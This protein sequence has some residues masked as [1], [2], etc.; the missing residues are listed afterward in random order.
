MEL[1]QIHPKPVRNSSCQVDI[2]LKLKAIKA[3]AMR[4]FLFFEH[5]GAKRTLRTFPRNRRER[6]RKSEGRSFDEA[7]KRHGVPAGNPRR[8]STQFM[9][10]PRN[11]STL[12][13]KGLPEERRNVTTWPIC[14]RQSEMGPLM[15]FQNGSV[16]APN[17]TFRFAMSLSLYPMMT[18]L[19]C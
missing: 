19:A 10:L 3:S 17:A 7:L 12:L 6:P 8:T 5:K 11:T 18:V 13:E 15:I 14:H 2:G 9:I 16:S 1:S 4:G